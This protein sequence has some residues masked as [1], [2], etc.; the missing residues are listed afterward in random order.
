MNEI[1][2]HDLDHICL[3]CKRQNDLWKLIDLALKR[4]PKPL[5]HLSWWAQAYEVK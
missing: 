3:K 2:N 1:L 5:N 4:D